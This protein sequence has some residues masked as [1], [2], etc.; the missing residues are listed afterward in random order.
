MK[1][2]WQLL[3]L[4]LVALVCLS[5]VKM[6]ALARVTAQVVNTDIFAV[7]PSGAEVAIDVDGNL[8]ATTDNDAT[9][10]TEALRWAAI[11][12]L[13]ATFGD[14]V[15]V[16]GDLTVTTA[17]VPPLTSLQT[18]TAAGT[19]AGDSCGGVKQIKADAAVTTS[20]TDTFTSTA[21]MTGLLPCPMDVV[22]VG[23]HTITLDNSLQFAS[24]SGSNVA[25]GSTDTVR[26]IAIAGEGWIQVGG[27]GN[28]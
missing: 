9:L 2:S 20:T 19:I 18:I 3:G 11:Y 28:N 15:S 27:T 25:L 17:I 7:G 24:A 21:S 16:A 8:L 4:V 22:N 12:V 23:S 13:D 26:V 10:G 1:K 14:D 5:Q 6:S